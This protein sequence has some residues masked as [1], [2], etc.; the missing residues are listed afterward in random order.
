MADTN[1]KG[2]DIVESPV[3]SGRTSP[4]NDRPNGDEHEGNGSHQDVTV[5]EALDESKKGYFAYFHTREFYVVLLLGQVLALCITAT[6]TFTNLL[7]V[8]GTSIPS[9]QTLFN[10]ILLNL[11]YTSYTIYRYGFKDWCRLIYKS[12][13]KYMIFAFFD[14]EGNYFVVKAY[15]Y[16]TI[17]SAQLIN[18][19]AIVIVVAVSF[20]LLRVRYHWA[21]YI[22]IIVCI[23]GMGVLFGSDHI[24]GSTAGEQKSRGDQIKGDLFA[25]LG[26]TCY[27]FANVTEEYLV[28]KRPLYEVLGQLG[29]Y[30]TVIMGVQAAIFDR[31]S[32]QTA[33]WT[34]EVGG[35]LTGYTI[36]LFIFYSLAPILFRLASAAFFNISLLTS[37]FWGVVIG[38]KVFQ[39]T[40]HWMYPIAFVLIVIGQCIYYLGRRVLGEATKPWLGRNQEK[41]VAGVGTAKK[42]INSN[43]G[44]VAN[45]V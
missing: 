2:A 27:G 11:V 6:N 7:S 22:G 40:I 20:L 29:L 43:A 3:T 32:F 35:Y 44:G 38:V 45:V 21:Q 23:G 17:L 34:G 36:C 24:T 37:N 10:Y 18:F 26:A 41:G 8:A 39:Y 5:A 31:G 33:N 42:K 13:W 9:F 14:V 25:L 4:R 12:G 28:S 19:W 16:T 30:A 15:Q 1:N